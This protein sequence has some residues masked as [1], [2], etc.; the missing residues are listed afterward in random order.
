MGTIEM[1]VGKRK[2][3]FEPVNTFS[4]LEI[5]DGR[6]AVKAIKDPKITAVDEPTFVRMSDTDFRNGTIEVDVLSKLLN[7]APDFARGFIG[8]AFR[9]DEHN[10]KFESIYIR[11]TNGR[12][13]DQVRRNRSVQYF[14]YPEYKFDRLRTE[15]PGKYETYAD[16]GLNEWIHMK[17]VAEGN[18]AFL[19]L[20]GSRQP[21]LVVHDLKHG[22]G[23]S[24]GIGLWVD[25][26]TEG[27]FAD[28]RIEHS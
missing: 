12:T 25:I 5:I 19:H 24:G 26:G 27:Y 7:D 15:T 10:S 8:V 13:D 28:I 17:I 11:P 21:V 16:M 22:A 18:S 3:L 20:N 1:H 9:I 23:L 2:M 6:E 14:S 4:S